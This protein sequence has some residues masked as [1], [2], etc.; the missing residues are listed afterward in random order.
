MSGGGTYE[1]F[2]HTADLGLFIHG[3][4]MREL[5]ETACEA[6]CAQLTDPAGVKLAES[7]ELALKA[8]DWDELL[9][10]WLA[11]L[12]YLYN[13]TGWL[14]R[15]AEIVSLEQGGLRAVVSGEPADPARHE[16]A[17][18]IKAVTWHGLGIETRGDGMLR[19]TVIFDV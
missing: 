18:E 12:L 10:A 17:A 7:R 13:G 16:I 1:N 3:R 15:T 9:R 6:L 2:E 5:F 4:N 19:A 8:R 11:E 14:A